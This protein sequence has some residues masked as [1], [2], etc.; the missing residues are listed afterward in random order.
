[1]QKSKPLTKPSKTSSKYRF[2]VIGLIGI[3]AWV[4][5]STIFPAFIRTQRGTIQAELSRISRLS[6]S[7]QS[8][9]LNKLSKATG[10]DQE[11]SRSLADWYK[12]HNRYDLAA[13]SYAAARPNLLVESAM[14]YADGY[15]Y[16]NAQKIAVQAQKTSQDP[17]ARALE[18]QA[19]INLNQVDSGCKQVSEINNQTKSNQRAIQLI[20]ACQI[21]RGEATNQYQALRLISLGVPNIA[22]KSL[23]N[24]T[25][26]SSTVSIALAGI[27]LRRQ[28]ISRGVQLY[29]EALDANPYDK[30]LLNSIVL[31][32]KES[33]NQ[34]ALALVKRARETQSIL[35]RY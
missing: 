2:L 25:V 14:S 12:R 28:D 3:C 4:L 31:T 8:T 23:Q 5:I 9:E 24:F 10:Y 27:Q 6:E 16:S 20:E 19:L 35:P 18:A 32:L 33:D 17:E 13:Q 26:K 11:V 22:E 21:I 1:M 34:K 30:E 7:Q 15:E 29:T